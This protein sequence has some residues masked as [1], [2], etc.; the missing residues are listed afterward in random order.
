MDFKNVENLLID[1]GWI[2]V[3]TLGTSYRYKKK[4]S[5]KS[6]SLSIPH[7]NLL[8]EDAIKKLESIT[9]LPLTES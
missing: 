8:S 5:S 9:G 6:I 4:D 1:N 3:R 2:C 7:D